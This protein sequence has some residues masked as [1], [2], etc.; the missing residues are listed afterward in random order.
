[1]EANDCEKVRANS[2]R[3]YLQEQLDCAVET[4]NGRSDWVATEPGRKDASHR[5]SPTPQSLMSTAARPS[6]TCH[7]RRS[8]L[9][10]RPA[11][12]PF[13]FE[14]ERPSQQFPEAA[15]SLG[16]EFHFPVRW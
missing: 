12:P 8:P 11:N 4:K 16:R 9:R 7:F 15:S 13:D 5:G 6:Q 14:L 10:C 2:M 1:M 3:A